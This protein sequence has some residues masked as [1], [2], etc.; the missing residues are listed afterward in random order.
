MK[1]NKEAKK[2]ERERVEERRDEVLSKGRKFK[3]PLQHAKYKVV[4]YTVIIA[5][6]AMAGLVTVGWVS[7]YK[8]QST[9]DMMYR[10]ASVLQ[11]P[12]GEVD[13]E[14]VSYGDYLM[15]YRSSLQTV[16]QQSGKLGDSDEDN[17]VRMTYKRAAMDSAEEYAYAAKLARENGVEVSDEDVSNSYEEHRKVGGTE[18]SEEAFL[19]IVTDNFGMSKDEY[20]RMLYL[21]LLKAKV[22]AATDEVAKQTAGRVEQAM[23]E[24]KAGGEGENS[25]ESGGE[26]GGGQPVDLSAVAEGLGEV[27]EYEETGGLVDS[28]N[29]D[30]GRAA[31]AAQL[32]PGEVSEKFVSSNGDG[33]YYV[34]LIDRNGEKVNY[35]SIKIPFNEFA[36]EMQE[37]RDAGVVREYIEL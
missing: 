7:L 36:K 30:G 21:N 18:Q 16:E 32:Q 35:A 6:L 27:V 15:I 14:R 31:R 29:I 34:K 2:T 24:M 5:V 8:G 22:M 17:E 28:K 1:T 13:G 12:V 25:D 23:A 4:I 26:N 11:L 37:L 20:R 33:Y 19:K 9:S 3:Y 10:I